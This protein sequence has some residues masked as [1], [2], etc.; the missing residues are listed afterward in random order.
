MLTSIRL[1]LFMYSSEMYLIAIFS[2]E[3]LPTKITFKS[4]GFLMDGW[5]VLVEHWFDGKCF[6]TKVALEGSWI[7]MHLS[8]VGFKSFLVTKTFTTFF[9]C[10]TFDVLMQNSNVLVQSRFGFEEFI[11][12]FTNPQCCIWNNE[13][14]LFKLC[15]KF[16]KGR[17]FLE[18]NGGKMYLPKYLTSRQKFEFFRTEKFKFLAGSQ[19]FWEIHLSAIM[20]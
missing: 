5:N 11:T 13:K 3:I 16:D 18:S 8:Y 15:Y 1:R 2:W 6:I 7:F 10:I 17:W 19:I 12:S 20:F 4:V 14:G 9:T